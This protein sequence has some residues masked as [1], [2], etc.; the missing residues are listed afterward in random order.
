[1]K[2][3]NRFGSIQ[4]FVSLKKNVKK[5]S[6]YGKENSLHNNKKKI[7]FKQKENKTNY[8]EN[9]NKAISFDIIKENLMTKLIFGTNNNLISKLTTIYSNLQ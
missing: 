2:H 5:K 4:Q 3:S 7:A 8:T 9:K 1:M 6:Y